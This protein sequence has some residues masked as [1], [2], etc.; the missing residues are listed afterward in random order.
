MYNLAEIV[1]QN[2]MI[3]IFYTD[4]I[5]QGLRSHIYECI[6]KRDMHSL[7]LFLKS[8]HQAVWKLCRRHGGAHHSI[9]VHFNV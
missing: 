9:I 4:R 6:M 7:D 3:A 1:C 8:T 5:V 2:T